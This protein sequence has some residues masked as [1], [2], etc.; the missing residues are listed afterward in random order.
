MFR[1]SYDK[2]TFDATDRSVLFLKSNKLVFPV[3]GSYINAQRAAFFLKGVQVSTSIGNLIKECIVNL[4]DEDPTGI[5][6]LLGIEEEAGT[7]YDL[8]G[9][10][11]TG[12]P[13]QKGIYINNGKKTI[14]K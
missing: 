4:D 9:R 2:L 10:K 14:I 11:L 1:G 7:W 8:N 3:N 6:E 12:K 13:A 5:A